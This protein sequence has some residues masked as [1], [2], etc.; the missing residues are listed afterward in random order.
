MC[1]TISKSVFRSERTGPV[2]GFPA[3]PN[4]LKPFFSLLLATYSYDSSVQV[5]ELGTIQ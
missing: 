1:L 2:L 4:L 5:E 3:L